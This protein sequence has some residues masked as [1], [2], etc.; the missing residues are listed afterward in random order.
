MSFTKTTSDDFT[1]INN[2]I[3]ERIEIIQHKKTGFYN[4]TK[5]TKLVHRLKREDEAA[6]IPAGSVKQPT[7][8]PV[9]SEK[10]ANTWFENKDTDELI[11][12]CK[13][14]TGF[15]E[16][17]YELASGTPKR[18]AG[19][20]VHRYLYDHFMAWLDKSYAMKVSIIR[21]SP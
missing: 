12:A 15:G 13:Q 8:I 16:V 21:V 1:T 10:R 19:T 6:E 2:G 18:F 5:M 9:G 14:Y 3:D 17:R 7:G 4:I 11:S 20:Y